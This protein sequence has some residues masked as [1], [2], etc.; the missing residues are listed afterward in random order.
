MATD[1]VNDT[2]RNGM[3][4]PWSGPAPVLPGG[5]RLAP[6]P[7]ESRKRGCRR[8][9]RL[10]LARAVTRDRIRARRLEPKWLRMLSTIR[11]VTA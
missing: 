10:G 9:R 6:P 1:A 8:L 11:Y 5:A 2:L 3:T 4:V 7:G